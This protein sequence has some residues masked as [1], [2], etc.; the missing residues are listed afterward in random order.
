MQRRSRNVRAFSV[1]E[2][3]SRSAILYV[4]CALLILDE[5]P[6]GGRMLQRSSLHWRA[7]QYCVVF[8]PHIRDSEKIAFADTNVRT[9]F[10]ND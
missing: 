2:L 6:R 8:E 5:S 10:W 3:I 9:L 1:P 7:V 4:R